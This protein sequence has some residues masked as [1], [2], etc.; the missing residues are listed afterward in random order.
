M[1]LALLAAV[2]GAVA[3]G[4]GSVLQAVAARRVALAG[5]HLLGVAREP[6]YVAGLG[7]DLVGWVLSLVALRQLPLF[8]VQAILAGSLAVTVVM[9]AAVFGSRVRRCDAW[10]V[11]V[12]VIALGVL[13]AAARPERAQTLHHTATAGLIAGVALVAAGTAAAA[14]WSGPVLTGAAGGIAFGGA[15]VAARAVHAQT[16][17]TGLL[18]QP[19]LLAVIAYGVVGMAGYAH[20]LERGQVGAV[21]AALWVAETVVPGAIGLAALGDHVRPGWAVP[22]VVAATAT[23]AATLVLAGS[24]AQDPVAAGG[25]PRPGGPVDGREA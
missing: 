7:F 8:A 19:L 22:T 15:A 23:L 9:A 17:V 20:A 3:Y 10:A 2:G 11:A 21:T 5:R 1:T 12:T 25:G 16:S 18:R 6:H 24:A 14:R 13:G 4:A